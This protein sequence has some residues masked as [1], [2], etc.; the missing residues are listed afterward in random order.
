MKNELKN[1]R[2]FFKEAAKK[3]LPILGMAVIAMAVPSTL[4]SCKKI[5]LGCDDVCT[6]A[7]KTTCKTT[8]VGG[9][10]CSCGSGCTTS[11]Y[12]RGCSS[13]CYSKCNAN[14]RF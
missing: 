2:E 13:T 11:C 3:T 9:A 14:T 12:N 5:S 10:K 7:C 6:N 4:Q 8:C 1:R